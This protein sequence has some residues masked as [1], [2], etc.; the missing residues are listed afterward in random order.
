MEYKE[1]ILSSIQSLRANPV[2]TGLT[3]LGMIIGTSAVIL[4]A[5]IGQ[6]AVTFITNELSIF[7]TNYFQINPGNNMMATFSGGSTEPLTMEDVKTI[8]NA[9]IANIENVAPFAM[10]SR[11]ITADDVS[12]AVAIYGITPAVID[13]LKPE[14]VY[15][16]GITNDEKDSK[17][18]VLGTDISEKL[19]GTDTNSVGESVTIDGFRYKIIGVS[20]SG[21]NLFGS[22]FNS[23]VMIPLEVVSNQLRGD[24]D[25]MEIDVSV[26]NSSAVNETMNEIKSL[27]RDKRGIKEGEESDFVITGFEESLGI[28]KTVTGLLTAL[29]AGI[30]AISLVVGGVGVMNIMLVSVVE[31]TKEIGLLKSIGAKEK[32]IL[33]QFLIESM[34]VT[35]LGGAIGICIGT[36]LALVIALLT[37][38]PFILSVPWIIIAVVVSSMIG[39]LFG[40]YPARRAAKLSPI[41]ALR[42]E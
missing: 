35:I 6:S 15:G 5:S 26:T 41:E 38:L 30:S 2:R 28:V 27:L 7:G 25:L 39:I 18:I 31:R 33:S 21:G 40:L 17:V 32:D 20:K 10:A 22:F 14:M 42:S 12:K 13:L 19:F 1:H 11:T 4:I 23:A 29:I 8:E 3:M 34:I 37:G 36:V 9:R 16:E 24:N